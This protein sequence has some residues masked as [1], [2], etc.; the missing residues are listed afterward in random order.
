MA[1]EVQYYV[2]T[3]GQ[4]ATEKSLLNWT[5]ISRESSRLDIRNTASVQSCEGHKP[6][7]PPPCVHQDS[8]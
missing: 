4:Q 3:L 7:A 6:I 5:T 8:S 1:K 2:Q